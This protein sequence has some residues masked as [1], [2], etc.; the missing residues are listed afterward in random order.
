[1]VE[2]SRTLVT[3]PAPSALDAAGNPVPIQLEVSG[4]SL[5]VEATPDS[6]A[7]FPILVDPI[8]ETYTWGGNTT[9]GLSSS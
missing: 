5:T 6:S 8:F 9:A 4:D 2:G 1:V 7:A 3:I